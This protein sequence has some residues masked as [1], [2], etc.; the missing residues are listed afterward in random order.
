[1]S[2]NKE[3]IAK[4]LTDVT[5]GCRLSDIRK[6][7]GVSAKSISHWRKKFKTADNVANWVSPPRRVFDLE[8]KIK[9]LQMIDNDGLPYKEVSDRINASTSLLCNW[10]RRKNHLFALY[11]SQTNSKESA[12][13]DTKQDDSSER[14][15]EAKTLKRRNEYLEAENAY[16]KALMKL[17][18]TPAPEFKKKEDTRQSGKSQTA[19]SE[20]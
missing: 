18:G 6:K 15:A 11:Y 14:E 9:A 12:M 3:T 13:N 2:Y 20:M 1:M 5:E 16:L 17:N 8:T 19:E 7:Y 4:V 10:H